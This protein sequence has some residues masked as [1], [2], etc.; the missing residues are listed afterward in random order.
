VTFQTTFNAHFAKGL[1]LVLK[2]KSQKTSLF[3]NL[4]LYFNYKK[5][6]IARGLFSFFICFSHFALRVAN[7]NKTQVSALHFSLFSFFCAFFC[8][9]LIFFNLFLKI[10]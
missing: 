2:E 7:A 4:S 1:I 9:I 10:S 6:S 8:R 5:P 3:A